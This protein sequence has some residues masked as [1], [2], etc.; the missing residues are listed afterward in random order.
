MSLKNQSKVL[1]IYHEMWER[2]Q[3]FIMF[4]GNLEELRGYFLEN[5]GTIL[6]LGEQDG[7]GNKYVKTVSERLIKKIDEHISN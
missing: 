5:L 2:I 1:E 3:E 6:A 7:I 4:G